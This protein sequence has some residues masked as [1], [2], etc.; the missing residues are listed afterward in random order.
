MTSNA[1]LGRR[2]RGRGNERDAGGAAPVNVSSIAL[3][4]AFWLLLLALPVSPQR[5]R[6]QL[7]MPPARGAARLLWGLPLD[8]NREAPEALE[9]LAGIGPMRARAITASRPFCQV[10]ELDRVAGIGPRT[11]LRLRG[12]VAVPDPPASC[13][14]PE[15]LMD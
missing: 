11:L 3:A 14:P 8:L 10:S 9:A 2:A 1:G 6:P 12:Q 5:L 7:P 15:P 13:M 4:G